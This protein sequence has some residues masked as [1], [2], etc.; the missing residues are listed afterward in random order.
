MYC[1]VCR[2]VKEVPNPLDVNYDLL[3]CD[4]EL[5]DAKS[6]EFKVGSFSV[7]SVW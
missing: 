7:C 5:L 2:Q 3:L 1:Y 6:Q 4:L